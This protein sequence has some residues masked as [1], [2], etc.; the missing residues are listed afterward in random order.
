M[1][2]KAL[3]AQVPSQDSRH[4]VGMVSYHHLGEQ[5]LQIG[6]VLMVCVV[7]AHYLDDMAALNKY[8]C[9]HLR[10]PRPQILGLDVVQN[11][12]CRHV[13]VQAHRT[14]PVQLAVHIWRF[15][16]RNWGSVQGSVSKGVNCTSY[17]EGDLSEASDNTA[18]VA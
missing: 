5:K 7:N 16:S 15:S 13:A 9:Y 14:L 8:V 17:A 18:R 1:A 3:V 10:R 4:D 2:T 11:A 12:T 6:L